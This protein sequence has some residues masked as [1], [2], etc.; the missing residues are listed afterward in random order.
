MA[1]YLI[2]SAKNGASALELQ[3]D[4]G[5]TYKS[6]WFMVHRIREAMANGDSGK[7]FGTIVAD[8]TYFGGKPSNRHGYTT[9]HGGQRRSTKTPILSVVDKETGEIR[10]TVIPNTKYKTIRSALEANVDLPRTTLHTDEAHH[11]DGLAAEHH[12]VNHTAGEYVRGD[13]STNM[14]EGF[15]SQFKRSVDGTYHNVSK[16]HLGR[17]AREFDFRYSTRRMSDGERAMNLI[18]RADGAFLSYRGLIATGPVALGSRSRP[19]GRTSQQRAG[20]AWLPQTSY[21]PAQ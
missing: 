15:F 4:L 18:H 6:A 8:E 12:A 21:R 19:S 2:V 7:L 14:A 13:V 10:S 1:I 9:G 3:R 16:E 20:A 11:F 5:I 17:Y